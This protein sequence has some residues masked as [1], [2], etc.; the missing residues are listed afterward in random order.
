MLLKKRYNLSALWVLWMLPSGLTY[1]LDGSSL[2]SDSR[3]YVRE[4]IQIHNAGE[5]TCRVSQWKGIDNL[6]L[7]V[8]IR[9]VSVPEDQS[10]HAIVRMRH[11]LSG[12]QNIQ[13]R[14]IEARNYFRVIADVSVGRADLAEMMLKEG[15]VR[16]NP[17]DLQA[18]VPVRNDF[19][20]EPDRFVEKNLS[21]RFIQPQV[22]S[23]YSRQSLEKAL[24][25]E[26]DL[27]ML[28]STTPLRE[29]LELIR[30]SVD[31][32]LPMVVIWSDLQ[33][34][35]DL[36]PDRPIG[37]AGFTRISPKLAMELILSSVSPG[38]QKPVA[39]QEDNI[40]LIVSSGFALRRM[41]SAVYDISELASIPAIADEY[42]S[43]T[44]GSTSSNSGGSGR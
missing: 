29:A 18:E 2:L 24:S 1:G 14:N 35:L 4:V 7:R 33:H 26:V 27:S 32:P 30:L 5:F 10:D 8:K 13:L 34:N 40:L 22:N 16:R 20:S 39:F 25:S 41:K 9:Y 42:N 31:P 6:R 37:V 21:T 44:G 28:D 38:I 12:S 19:L 3:C 36:D 17:S 15:I 11:Y 43:R 23:L